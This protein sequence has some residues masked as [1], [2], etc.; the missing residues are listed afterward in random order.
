MSGSHH[1]HSLVVAS[2]AFCAGALPAVGVF[3]MLAAAWL[4]KLRRSE[5]RPARP[6]AVRGAIAARFAVLP[7]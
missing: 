4:E 3:A 5:R 2:I 7:D 6:G 1:E